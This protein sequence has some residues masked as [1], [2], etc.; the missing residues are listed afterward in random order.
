M[1]DGHDREH[2]E[3]RYERC[4]DTKAEV[5]LD[6]LHPHLLP[7]LAVA[8]RT[9]R[10]RGGEQQERDAKVRDARFHCCGEDGRAA[11]VDPAVSHADRR[12]TSLRTAPR[13]CHALQV[14]AGLSLD[15]AP[16]CSPPPSRLPLAR[17]ASA[18]PSSRGLGHCPFTAATRVR[19]PLGSFEKHARN[20]E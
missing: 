18:A 6:D 19:I 4:G 10:R 8:N 9:R 14:P 20:A 7:R 13:H 2:D 16:D 12:M 5:M 15:R 11:A 3:E 1:H 17:H